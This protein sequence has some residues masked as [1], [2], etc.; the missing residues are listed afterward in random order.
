MEITVGLTDQALDP[1]A[2]IGTVTDPT[3]GG[4]ASFVG[5]VRDSAAVD[6]HAD[7]PVVA[8]E[9]E[10]HPELAEEKLHAICQEA[11]SRYGLVKVVALH[12]VGRCSLG[13]P[14]V[15][16]AC[17]SPH[18]AEAIGGCRFII[19][20]VKGSVPIFKKELYE[21]GS[22]WVESHA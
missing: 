7:K 15:V 1:G 21:D 12:R 18:R 6:G 4:I 8:L 19:D 13:D 3:C 5:T 20:E 10:A 16:V 11:V 17:S 2:A 9:Y 22:A 14:T